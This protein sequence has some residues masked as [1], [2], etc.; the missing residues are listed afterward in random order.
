[1]ILISLL[2]TMA[3]GDWF[4]TV[5]GLTI[6]TVAHPTKPECALH[7]IEIDNDNNRVNFI[8]EC[9]FKDGFD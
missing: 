2:L 8:T 5:D 9:I 7:H 4:V 3:T 1:M 6:V